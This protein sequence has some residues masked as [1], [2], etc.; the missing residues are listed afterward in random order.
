M[1][2]LYTIIHEYNQLYDKF[3]KTIN[4]ID[5]SLMYD[6]N[7]WKQSIILIMLSITFLLYD[8]VIKIFNYYIDN[9]SIIF[10]YYT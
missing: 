4:Y 7:P 3:M 9:L 10:M 8:Y 1:H 6:G 2:V 5:Y